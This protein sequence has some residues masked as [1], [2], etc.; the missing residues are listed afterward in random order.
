MDM[1]MTADQMLADPAL[2]A[3]AKEM[4]GD[5]DPDKS[6]QLVG[7][8]WVPSLWDRRRCVSQVVADIAATQGGLV[9]GPQVLFQIT[10]WAADDGDEL[11]Q[12][13]FRWMRAVGIA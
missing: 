1:D 9:N 5:R 12:N 7:T 4:C 8:N 11:S 2:T 3:A 13:L 10:K 6:W